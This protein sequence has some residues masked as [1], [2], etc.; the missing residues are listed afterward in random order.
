MQ[1]WQ[2]RLHRSVTETRRLRSVRPKTSA[3]FIKGAY[4][5]RPGRKQPLPGAVPDA[6]SG[7]LRL[8]APATIRE[9][10]RLRD[11]ESPAEG[12]GGEGGRPI[13]APKQ[14]APSKRAAGDRWPGCG[15]RPARGPP[16]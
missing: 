3:R 15:S 10:R 7:K 13:L 1:Y 11:S 16:G 12:F 4:S 6:R 9:K 2:R 14:F 5:G 8:T